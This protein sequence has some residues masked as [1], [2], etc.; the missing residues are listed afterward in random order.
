M[1][2]SRGSK[3]T[4]NSSMRADVTEALTRALFDEWAARGLSA[5][6]LEAVARRA[7]V[8]KAALYRRWSCKLDMVK[9]RLYTV[10]LTIT[11]VE[12]QGSLHGDVLAFLFVVRRLFRHPLLKRIVADIHAEQTRNPEVRE[13]LESFQLERRK[14]MD[15]VLSRAIE[16]GEL[17]TNPNLELMKDILASPLYWREIVL[18]KRIN[19][20]D[21]H[22]LADALCAALKAL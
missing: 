20:A 11:E 13:M 9:D 8:G 22:N 2:R 12:D 21:V 17:R 5:L 18:Q 10:G 14:R 4:R 7:G 15:C 19:K 16:R 6:S 3:K 1:I